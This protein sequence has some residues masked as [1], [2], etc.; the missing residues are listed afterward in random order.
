MPNTRGRF[1]TFEGI[2]CAGKGTQIALAI[3]YLKTHHVKIMGYHE[4]GGTPYGE[5]LRMLL[6][7]P[8]KAMMAL[9]NEFKDH[10]DFPDIKILLDKALKNELNIFR[11][12]QC[13]LFMFE[14]VRAEFSKLMRGLLDTGI[15]IISDRFADSTTAYQGYGHG[16]NLRYVEEMNRIAVAGLWPDLTF[17]LDITIEE[18][19]KRVALQSKEKNAFFEQHCNQE[20]FER[21][22]HGYLEIAKAEPTRFLVINGDQP[23]EQVFEKISPH[24]DWL[25]GIKQT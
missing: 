1:I 24:L 17:F 10:S 7:H 8:Q 25:F 11:V 18:M 16:L 22:R 14:A 13:E 19:I 15:N 5:A 23:K 2:E 12:P 3:D 20:F 9:F 21:V 4:P 6:K